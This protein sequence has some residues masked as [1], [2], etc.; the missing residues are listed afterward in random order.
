[1]E[2][3]SL[4]NA[5]KELFPA[6]MNSMTAMLERKQSFIARA[7]QA[8][9]DPQLG[10]S[11]VNTMA[12]D[13]LFELWTELDYQKIQKMHKWY[14][15]WPSRLS[16]DQ[17]LA[18]IFFGTFSIETLNINVR[19]DVALKQEL[20]LLWQRH[21]VLFNAFSKDEVLSF[22]HRVMLMS[23][24]PLVPDIIGCN[25]DVMLREQ[26]YR[27]YGTR[28]NVAEEDHEQL[29]QDAQ[30]YAQ[31]I[32]ENDGK[33]K[34]GKKKA[35]SPELVTM[36]TDVMETFNLSRQFHRKVFGKEII[37]PDIHINK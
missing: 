5:H 12:L 16:K 15:Q 25:D 34:V 28:Y 17:K 23:E 20:Y 26:A 27:Y 7:K 30:L 13:D 8:F 11:V 33:L 37:R 18:V 36:M 24:S 19:S 6:D 29:S 1:M 31:L 35:R 9:S 3:G 21:Q 32:V 4:V 22:I 2:L 14:Q 10:H